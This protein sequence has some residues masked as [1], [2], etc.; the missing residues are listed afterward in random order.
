MAR[1]V[2]VLP[3]WLGLMAQPAVPAPVRQ[4]W[5]GTQGILP[6]R[7]WR[8]LPGQQEAIRE[9]VGLDQLELVGLGP[10]AG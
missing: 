10:P 2:G 6:L 8:L 5:S 3:V 1:W 4:G 7:P 9:L